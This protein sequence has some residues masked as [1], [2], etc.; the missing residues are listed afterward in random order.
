MTKF[1]N[2]RGSGY[3]RP[4]PV[5][6]IRNVFKRFDTFGI[7]MPGFNVQGQTKMNTAIGGVFTVFIMFATIAY[8]AVKSIHLASGHNPVI[9]VFTETNY[10]SAEDVVNLSESG[11]R[12]A[13]TVE[14]FVDQLAKR[15]PRY[16]KWF[17]RLVGTLDGEEFETV[18]PH[19]V[20][21]DEDWKGFNQV[22]SRSAFEFDRMRTSEDRG[23]L[24]IDWTDNITIY[25]EENRSKKY[26]RLEFVFVPC[27][28]IH[29]HLGYTGDKV[30]D[31]CIADL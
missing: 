21:T 4:Q 15:D 1:S 22:S 11:F 24:C 30:A 7:E 25:G 12:M 10:Y 14:G 18:I 17:V 8:S 19:H 27:N 20:C 26:Q 2:G 16:V 23:F 29:T 3:G 31:E 13:F 28:Y 9:N 5:W 6:H